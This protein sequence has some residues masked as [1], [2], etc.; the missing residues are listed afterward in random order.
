LQGSVV[1][2]INAARPDLLLVGLGNPRQEHWIDANLKH[3]EVGVVAGVGALIDFLS[4]SI[5]RAPR[6]VRRI[7][8]EWAFRLALEP[9]R[10]FMRYVIGNP[11]F[12][13][14]SIRYLARPRGA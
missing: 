14:R 1:D 4:D 6:F 9:R 3:L 2:A 11:A 12:L 8:L 13:V 7:R 10:M 5:P